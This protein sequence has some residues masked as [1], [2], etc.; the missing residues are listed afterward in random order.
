MSPP[1]VTPATQNPEKLP[2]VRPLSTLSDAPP[3]RLA[4]TT[5]RTW[6]LW[7]EVKI[8]VTSGMTAPAR[9]PQVMMVA[10]FHQRLVFPLMLPISAHEAAYVARMEVIEA[11][12]TRAVS[13]ASKFIVRAFSYLRREIASLMK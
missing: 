9:V 8:L 3:S 2:A 1:M 11:I 10:S 5:S 13:G 7:V 4:V 6:P 12:H